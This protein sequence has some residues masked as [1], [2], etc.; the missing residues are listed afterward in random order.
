MTFLYSDD[1]DGRDDGR[2]DDRIR[3]EK[4]RK[5]RKLCC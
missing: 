4:K 2:D 1:G 3:K 5:E